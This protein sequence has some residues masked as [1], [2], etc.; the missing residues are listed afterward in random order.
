MVAVAP[1]RAQRPLGR[2]WAG[3]GSHRSAAVPARTP[4]RTDGPTIAQEEKS[5]P[6]QVARA[7]NT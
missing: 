6:P 3:A 4:Q 2:W 5:R 1:V 7:R